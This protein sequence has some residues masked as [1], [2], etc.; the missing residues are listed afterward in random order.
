MFAN[1]VPDQQTVG[2]LPES[3]EKQLAK[4][5]ARFKEERKLPGNN[6]ERG[7]AFRLQFLCEELV[8]IKSQQAILAQE[9][10]QN[11][12]GRT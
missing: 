11:N 7:D 2:S 1:A 10:G 12:G 4:L 6:R 8:K 3:I 5:Q 9:S